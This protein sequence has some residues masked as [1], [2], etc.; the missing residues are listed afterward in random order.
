M[1][2][3][4]VG[5]IF[6]A[7]RSRSRTHENTPETTLSD[8][9]EA[10]GHD[11]QRI[12]HDT[13]VP[14]DA[15]DVIHV[16]HAGRAAYLCAGQRERSAPFVFTGHAG[17]MLCG[18][19][20]SRTRV[21]AFH[22]ILRNADA[23]VALSQAEFGFLQSVVGVS[24]DIQVI[25]NGI[26][27][28][29]ALEPLDSDRADILFAGQLTPLKGVETLIRAF[30]KSGLARRGVGLK[31]A[32]HNDAWEQPMREL[33][34]SMGLATDVH[35]LGPL[36]AKQLCDT[37]ARSRLLALPSYAESRPSVIAEAHL[38]GT[39]VIASA[40]GGNAEIVGEYGL[41]V[42]AGDVPGWAHALRMA[43]DIDWSVADRAAMRARCLQLHDVDAMV[44]AHVALY[45]RAIAAGPR[46]GRTL[47]NRLRRKVLAAGARIK[48]R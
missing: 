27:A 5:G 24:T 20:P 44:A 40:V 23:L 4:V 43:Y 16:H 14:G 26:P 29:Y 21:R 8:G 28:A 33:S 36:S 12:G 17:Q 7:G 32:Y 47:A 13:F 3:A 30:A 1:R 15:F 6:G 37:L 19:E 22:E 34:T 48:Y 9:L 18:M 39:P 46:Q 42:P 25:P 45:E 31:F 10:L 35:F 38:S 2:I 41:L 11:V